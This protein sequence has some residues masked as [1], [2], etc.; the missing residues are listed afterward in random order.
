MAK[1]LIL[2]ILAGYTRPVVSI[3]EDITCLLDTGADTPVWTQGSE[4]LKKVFH[5]EKIEGKRF[6]LSGFGKEPVAAG[7]YS[8]LDD[9]YVEKVYSFAMNENTVV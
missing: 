5:A 8:S 2:K 6:I 3:G 7:V 4:S 9:R 1:L